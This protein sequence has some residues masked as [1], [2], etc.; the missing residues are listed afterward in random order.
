MREANAY[1]DKHAL[2]PIRVADVVAH[3]GVSARLANLRFS[4][5]TGHSIQAELVARR[6]AEVERLLSDTDCSM[7]RIATRCGFRSQT[8]LAN[9]F[10]SHLGMSMRAYRRQSHA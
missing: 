5:A 2:E 1:L 7:S 4:E 3:T 6:L 10:A 9:L 8:V